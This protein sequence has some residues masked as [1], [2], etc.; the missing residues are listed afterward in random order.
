ME[1]LIEKYP[2]MEQEDENVQ[3]LM[4]GLRLK[5]KMVSAA[6]GVKLEYNR[7]PNSSFKDKEIEFWVEILGFN[8]MNRIQFL[9]VN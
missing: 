9:I 7:Y 1:V 2:L 8:L 3:E 5:L 4:D 6:V